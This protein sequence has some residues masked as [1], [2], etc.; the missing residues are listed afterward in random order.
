LEGIH[1]LE[2]VQGLRESLVRYFPCLLN[3]LSETQ[4]QST[5]K[6]KMIEK[7]KTEESDI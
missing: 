6:E 5:K 2:M 4:P 7:N 1:A 3:C